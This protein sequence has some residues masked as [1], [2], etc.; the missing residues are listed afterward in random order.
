[1]YV[2]LC[3]NLKL[4]SSFNIFDKHSLQLCK[5]IQETNL[6]LFECA[7]AQLSS[8]LIVN[9]RILR[10]TLCQILSEEAKIFDLGEQ[11][12]Y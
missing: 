8:A 9:Q 3:Q 7:H 10:L 1:M 2:I 4:K 6:H 12:S 11:V 5:N